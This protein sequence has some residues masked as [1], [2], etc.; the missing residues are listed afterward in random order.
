MKKVS[1]LLLALLV[2]SS[3]YAQDGRSFQKL[4]ETP[5]KKEI[6]ENGD[7]FLQA[8]FTE[9]FTGEKDKSK[10][11]VNT[12]QNYAPYN[13]PNASVA[14]VKKY[15][16]EA[17]AEFNVPFAILDAIAKTYGNY[18]MTGKS[19]YGSFGMMGLV[20]NEKV[21][22]VLEASKLTGVAVDMIRN[23]SRQ[24][25][26]AAAAL[27]SN[28]AGKNQNS[29]NL[30]DWFGAVKQL[31][32]LNEDETREL[33]AI[34][35]YKVMNEGRSSITLWKEE[36]TVAPQ[37]NKQISD[38]VSA[39]NEKIEKAGLFPTKNNRGATSGTIEYAGAIS[40][41][42]D[43]N[44]S[45]RNGRTID[46]WVNH[47]IGEGTVAGA[48]SWF[49]TCRG[50]NGS[51]AHFIV[52]VDGK[53]YQVVP[54]ASKSWH[55]G[56]SGQ[57]NNERSIGT[58]HDVTTNTPSNWNN[59]TLL[60]ASTDLA[61]FF[62]NT[63]NIS[64]TRSLPGIRGHQEMPGTSTDCPANLPWTTWMN[65]LN[66][67]TSPTNNV[68][69]LNTPTAGASVAS[70]VKLT[71]STS[72]SGASCRIQVSRVNTGWTAANGF[73]TQSVATTNVPVNYSTAGL[74]NY[75]WPN[76]GTTTANLP[77][78]GNTYYWTV[79]SYSSAT[80]TS[81]YSAVRSFT[82]SFT[83][84]NTESINNADFVVYPNPSNGEISINFNTNSR[85]ATVTLFDMSGNQIFEK[86]HQTQKGNNNLKESMAG[87][88]NGNYILIL[89]DGE[90]VSKQN[91]IIQK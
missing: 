81:S 52:A 57:P 38:L 31:T 48:I 86:N 87:I 15:L 44:Y 14:T 88:K 78:A 23:N 72:V 91:I 46:T 54:V 24:H 37:N 71:W 84:R 39:Y 56:A 80:G 18:T 58:E 26:R 42:T 59:S 3:I 40:A 90:K 62:C 67:V 5:I 89:N 85:N 50:D 6:K 35:Y 68:P 17:S 63:K 60:K 21:N 20:E 69:T 36:G 64:K 2:T 61:R 77:V 13:K 43:C 28:Y 8:D 76:S 19:E 75:T 33:Q 83:S 53:V 7:V 10:V 47:Y 30:V 73:T 70:P 49:R 41:F 32:G 29:N 45:S 34:D 22:K 4:M 65:L 11:S 25:I 1:K 79:R 82:V 66:S 55:A 16:K 74:L 51:S 27:L 9:V 12:L